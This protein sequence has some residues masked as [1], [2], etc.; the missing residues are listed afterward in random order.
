MGDGDSPA[1]PF[2]PLPQPA[3]DVDFGGH[4]ADPLILV[5][6]ERTAQAIEKDARISSQN[7]SV[8]AASNS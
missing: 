5:A 4:L 2:E 3:G 7:A 8:A 6:G 1:K